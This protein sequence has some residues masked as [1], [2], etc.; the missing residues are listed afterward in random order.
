MKIKNGKSKNKKPAF[1]PQYKV[2]KTIFN[3][4]GIKKS[5]Y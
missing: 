1:G 4:A 2:Q 5:T 3:A